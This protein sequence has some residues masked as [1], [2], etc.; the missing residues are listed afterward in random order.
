MNVQVFDGKQKLLYMI[1]GQDATNIHKNLCDMGCYIS[2]STIR[3]A[4]NQGKTCIQVFMDINIK[5][6]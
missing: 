1:N 2:I 4:L 3:K 5:I 6:Q